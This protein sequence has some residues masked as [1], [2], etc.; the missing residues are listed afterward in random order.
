MSNQDP[1]IADA[2]GTPATAEPVP[3]NER[4]GSLD[5][6]RGVAILGMNIYALAL[7]FTAYSNPLVMGGTDTLNLGTWFFTHIFLTR[8]S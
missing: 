4:V 3:G 1:D 2:A 8:S 5:I 7:P 6:L